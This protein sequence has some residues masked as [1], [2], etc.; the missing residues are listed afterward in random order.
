MEDDN[1]MIILIIY[2]ILL[3]VYDVNIKLV[4]QRLMHWEAAKLL[5]AKVQGRPLPRLA[6]TTRRL[7]YPRIDPVS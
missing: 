5:V 4:F 3:S 6:M 1:G 2:A 7:N